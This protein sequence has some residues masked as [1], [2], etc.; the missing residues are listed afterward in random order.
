M[1]NTICAVLKLIL[2]KV[3]LVMLWSSLFYDQGD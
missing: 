2:L 1:P 3:S